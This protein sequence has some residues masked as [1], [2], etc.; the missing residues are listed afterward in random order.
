AVHPSDMCVA[1]AALEARIRVT[2]PK[3]E[4]VIAMEDFH[5]LPGTTPHQDT[6]LRPDELITSIDLPPSL[7]AAHSH[8]IKV[9]DRASYE[10]ALVSAAAALDLQSGTIRS[11]RI[12]L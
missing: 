6:N 11:A 7:F 3:G 2:G 8:Y 4:R 10:F 5:R 9:R 1:L 12:A